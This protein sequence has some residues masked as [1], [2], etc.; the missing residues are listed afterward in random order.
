MRNLLWLIALTASVSPAQMTWT[1]SMPASHPAGR[2][3]FAMAYDSARERVV[4]FGGDGIVSG[5]S[6]AA[7][8]WE[9]DGDDWTLIPTVAPPPRRALH[10]MA[11]DEARGECIV[12]GGIGPNVSNGTWAWDGVSWTLRSVGGPPRSTHHK[13]AYDAVRECV[14]MYGG[15]HGVSH[16]L[17]E[18][19]WLWDG[20]SW[21]LAPSVP[22]FSQSV[23]VSADTTVDEWLSTSNF[24]LDPDV[25]AGR[26]IAIGGPTT[27][28]RGYFRFD[29]SSWI[30]VNPS[31]AT[32]RLYQTTPVGAGCVSKDLYAVNDAWI[33]SQL[34]WDTQPSYGPNLVSF[35]CP[36]SSPGWKEFDV[37]TLVRDWNLGVRENHGLVIRDGFELAGPARPVVCTSGE[38][39]PASQRPELVMEFGPVQPPGTANHAM[40][41]DAARGRVVMVTIGATY[42]WTGSHWEQVGGGPV[43]WGHAA[44]GYDTDRERI[45]LHG[46]GTNQFGFRSTETW[47]WDGFTW[48][49]YTAGPARW[50]HAMAYDQARHQM[51]LFGGEDTQSSDMDETW[52]YEPTVPASITLLDPG[53][54]GSN[55]IPTLTTIGVPIAGNSEFALRVGNV[56]P[57]ALA[58]V[59]IAFDTFP[60]AV[61]GC[62]VNGELPWIALTTTASGSFAEFPLGLPPHVAGWDVYVQ[63]GGVD[64][65]GSFLNVLALTESL[66]LVIGD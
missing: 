64:P 46:G 31:R 65:N 14:V 49:P 23:P 48:T 29:L 58:F 54:N 22:P 24:G 38:G 28:T 50:K 20:T 19:T 41:Y 5:S 8:T 26:M 60:I 6:P 44:L 35:S 12:F 30:G 52:L 17:L 2:I 45:V 37:T 47:E 33:E 13:M 7:D 55:G 36:D 56:L 11:Y 39:L 10:A 42:E 51:L 21:T 25:R 18:D 16:Y 61:G 57:G 9:W 3:N 43:A 63:G 32:L 4:V 62:V 66:H 15:L 40:A 53:C 27:P 1:E 59:G 34:T